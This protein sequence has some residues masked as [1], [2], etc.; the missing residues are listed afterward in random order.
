MSLP[1]RT[2]FTQVTDSAVP[3]V[4]IPV[5]S[6]T[7][8][9]LESWPQSLPNIEDHPLTS[10]SPPFAS[11]PFESFEPFAE[12]GSEQTYASTPD[13]SYW[14]PASVSLSE[15]STP[16]HPSQ[17]PARRSSLPFG[18]LQADNHLVFRLQ[19]EL[20]RPSDHFPKERIQ[21]VDEVRRVKRRAQNRAA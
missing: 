11:N 9:E 4:L 12:N 3:P 7:S 2:P 19:T 17:I 1:Y 15:F 6:S 21:T 8:S 20:T 18:T 10:F 16:F 5:V 14:T 13:S